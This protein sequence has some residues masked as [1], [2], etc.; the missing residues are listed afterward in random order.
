MHIGP[1]NTFRQLTIHI[2]YQA[3]IA[4]LAGDVT[5]NLRVKFKMNETTNYTLLT[6]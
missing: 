1:N 6:A 5:D 4:K 2:Q 3:L